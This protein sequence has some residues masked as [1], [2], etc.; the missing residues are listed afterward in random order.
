M[1]G[2]STQSGEITFTIPNAAGSGSL[3]INLSGVQDQL[4]LQ[5]R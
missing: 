4:P 3:S 2:R 1:D 5:V